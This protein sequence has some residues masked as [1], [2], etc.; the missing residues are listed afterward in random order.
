ML[1]LAQALR[2]R[3]RLEVTCGL[4]SGGFYWLGPVQL[5]SGLWHN[6]YSLL[7]MAFFLEVDWS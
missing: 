6:L 7:H 3:L 1:Y 5:V 2:R 4:Y